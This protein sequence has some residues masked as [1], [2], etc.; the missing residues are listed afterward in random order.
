MSATSGWENLY[1]EELYAFFTPVLII[2]S[3]PWEELGEP[4]HA[5]LSRMLTRLNLNLASVH[6]IV[7]DRFSIEELSIYSPSK[8]LAFGATL[9]SQVNLYENI[10]MGEVS[11]ILSE[12]IDQLDD[13]K[14]KTLW[15]ALKL[16]FNL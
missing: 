10:S 6:I 3:K 2:L 12:S 4:E 13:F 16:M 11:I 9:H 1:Q 5:T 7:R 8:V 14:K 15:A